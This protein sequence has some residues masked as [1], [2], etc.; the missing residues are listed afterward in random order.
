MSI[1]KRIAKLKFNLNS[2]SILNNKNNFNEY[3]INKH[4]Y[5]IDHIYPKKAFIDNN[6]D[7]KYDMKVVYE[8]C[9]SIEN[10]QILSKYD[11]LWKNSKYNNEEFLL[12]FNWKLTQRKIDNNG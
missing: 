7:I 10:L 2:I 3:L 1:K 4:K 12:W 11:N 9:N 6:L 5:H 8:I